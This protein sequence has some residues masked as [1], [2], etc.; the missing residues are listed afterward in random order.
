M[1]SVALRA[2][3]GSVE[4]AREEMEMDRVWTSAAV[5]LKRDIA[6]SCR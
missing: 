1:V 6:D 3:M 4:A 5:R 2:W